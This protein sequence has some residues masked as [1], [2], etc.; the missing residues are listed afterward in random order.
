MIRAL[1]PTQIQQ[2]AV[3]YFDRKNFY[4]FVLLPETSKPVSN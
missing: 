4:K 2:A 3:R 1:T